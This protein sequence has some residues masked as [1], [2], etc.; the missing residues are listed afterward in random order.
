MWLHF[1]FKPRQQPS[2]GHCRDQQNTGG[3]HQRLQ[4]G[5]SFELEHPEITRRNSQ[6]LVPL[7]VS[8]EI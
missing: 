3:H 7:F 5:K 4:K 6:G 2:H 8:G 1:F